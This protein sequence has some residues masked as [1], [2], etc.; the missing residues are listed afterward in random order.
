MATACS[1]P[2]LSGIDFPGA[3]VAPEGN[4]PRGIIVP[5]LSRC[6]YVSIGLPGCFHEFGVLDLCQWES[7]VSIKLLNFKDTLQTCLEHASIGQV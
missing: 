4:E 1:D 7:K 5:A 2:H 3:Q 6:M